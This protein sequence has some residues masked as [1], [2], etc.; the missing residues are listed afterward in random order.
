[1]QVVKK[2]YNS[3]WYQR[4]DLNLFAFLVLFLNV[5]MPVKIIALVF[6]LALNRKLFL[7]KSLYRHKFIWFYFSLIGIALV[8]L[9]LA[10]PTLTV[11]YLVTAAIGILFWSLCAGA[12]F[13]VSWY[14][15]KIST[16]K[17]NATITLFFIANAAVTFGQLLFIIWDAG[18]INPYLYQGMRQK[19]FIGTGDLMTGISFD[20]STTNAIL[21][22][23]G[24]VYF[25]RRNKIA[26]TLMCMIVLLLTA[27]NFVNVLILLVLMLIFI[28]Q[29]SKVQ[30]S[31]NLVCL[32][33]L[34]TFMVKV[35]PQN[36]SYV[37]GIYNEALNKK[38]ARKTNLQPD[39]PLME[40]PDS[41]LTA[42]EKKQK[43]A[44]Q[45]LD[46]IATVSVQIKQKEDSLKPPA[47][48]PSSSTVPVS[49]PAIPK[50]D[51]HSEPF[52]RRRDT[53][54]SQREL[55]EFAI[56]TVPAFDTTLQPIKSRKLPG[57]II[58]F[59]Q[60]YTFLKAHPLKII[61]GT[62]IGKFSSKLAFRATGLQIAGGYP[63]N[64]AYTDPDFLNN[65]LR[66]YLDYFS[67]DMA[68][69]SV[70][71]SPN[72][73]YDQLI[74]EYGVLGVLA[75]LLLYLGFY[76]KHLKKLKYGWPLL[77][78][79][80]GAFGVDYWFEQLSIVIVFELLML[81]DIKETKEANE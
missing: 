28:F 7:D 68:L 57:K 59:Q 30:K 12:A 21:N 31:V 29:S 74:A 1:M 39:I 5:K 41:L 64:F 52:Q 49:K 54:G 75:F 3:G 40:K 70:V 53:T 32:F 61:T 35:S 51:I 4:I 65:H 23:F 71:N 46:S 15:T 27:S 37:R 56:S 43:I 66:L 42:E 34:V 25:L 48:Q 60:T 67:K 50:P 47:L 80:L 62:G 18:S 78:L 14:V 22:A 45:Y 2:I 81:L 36:D 19:Y 6:F 38:T 11:P 79:L 55:L 8:N 13:L 17:L 63:K 9:A 58:A 69:H 44:L 24:V 20:V 33:L 26:L 10:I 73:V 16:G 76:V 77:L 72:T